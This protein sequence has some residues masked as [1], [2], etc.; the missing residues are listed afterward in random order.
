MSPDTQ[1]TLEHM[2]VLVRRRRTQENILY[3]LNNRIKA[4]ER[5]GVELT[6]EFNS[7]LRELHRVSLN[8]NKCLERDIERACKQLPVYSTW[9][10]TTHGLGPL[11]IGLILGSLST[12][13]ELRSP[14]DFATVAKLW[15][16]FGF[17]VDDGSAERNKGFDRDVGDISG[18]APW[19]KA[20]V[21]GRIVEPVVRG[22]EGVSKNGAV[23]KA[24]PYRVYYDTVKQHYRERNDLGEFAERAAHDLVTK[25]GGTVLQRE[26][27][28][29]GRLPDLHIDNMARRAVGKQ[30]LKDL[31]LAWREAEAENLS[32]AA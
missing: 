16:Y 7:T 3:G 5:A 19:R 15:R 22:T 6:D 32:V 17:A 4:A 18:G 26:S 8:D 23:R 9:I 11:G 20:I 12:M 10:K 2:A 14:E 1:Q 24:G 28:S 27:W 25:K 21:I 30:I 13:N 31:W 29:A